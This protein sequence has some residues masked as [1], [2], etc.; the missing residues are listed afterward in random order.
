MPAPEPDR[1]LQ[2]FLK[3]GSNPATP[4]TNITTP[5]T[6]IHVGRSAG[7]PVKNREMSELAESMAHAPQGANPMPPASRANTA[8]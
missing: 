3:A 8:A 5:P 2:I 1:Y 4:A 6:G 7:A